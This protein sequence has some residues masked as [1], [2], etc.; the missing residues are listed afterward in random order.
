MFVNT[1]TECDLEIAQT[2][3][4]GA[5]LAEMAVFVSVERDPD[6]AA[7]SSQVVNHALRGFWGPVEYPILAIWCRRAP[8]FG[9]Q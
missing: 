7:K 9:R 6:L 8:R 1:G 4:A 2:F 3:F 5:F